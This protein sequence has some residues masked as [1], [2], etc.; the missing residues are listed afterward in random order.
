MPQLPPGILNG[1]EGPH[2]T[3]LF[4]DRCDVA[5]RR[6]RLFLMAAQLQMTGNLVLQIAVELPAFQKGPDAES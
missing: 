2:V 1:K 3:A 5:E 4:P 6:A